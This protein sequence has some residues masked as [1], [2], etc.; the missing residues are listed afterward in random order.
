PEVYHALNPALIQEITKAVNTASDDN[1]VRV[2]VLTSEGEKAFCS[3]ADLKEEF[4]I[5]NTIG[6]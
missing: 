3:G 1:E 4:R 5:A 6:L 2:I